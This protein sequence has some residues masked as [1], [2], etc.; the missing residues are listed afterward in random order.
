[1]K[2]AAAFTAKVNEDLANQSGGGMGI[3]VSNEDR[4]DDVD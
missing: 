2:Q 1:M 4:Y 3:G